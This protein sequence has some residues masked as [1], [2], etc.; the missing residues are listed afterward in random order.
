MGGSLGSRVFEK[1]ANRAGQHAE[2]VEKK[3]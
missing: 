1:P 2:A 3:E